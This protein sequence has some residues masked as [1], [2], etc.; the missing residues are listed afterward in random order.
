MA[1]RNALPMFYESGAGARASQRAALRS[2]S[3]RGKTLAPRTYGYAAAVRIPER[4]TSQIAT[5]ARTPELFVHEGARQALERRL[6]ASHTGP[7][8]LSI[9]DN[10]HSIISHRLARGVLKARI[11]H[12][13][14]D[15]PRGVVDALVRYVTRGERHASTLVG[16]FIEANGSRIDTRRR[17]L[18]LH[19]LGAHHDLLKIFEDVNARY[20]DGQCHALVTWGRKVVRPGGRNRKP[21]VSIKL[22][23]YSQTERVIRIHPVLDRQWVPRYFVA[24][25]LYH[26]MLHHMMPTS[27]GQAGRS[28]ATLH[29]PEFR[30]RERK[31]RHYER[32]IAW[33]RAHIARLLRA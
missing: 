32:A 12:M 6:Q 15:A 27:R 31:F 29:P 21:R 7:V 14:L 26:E 25:V 17:R 28:R 4:I 30:E 16:D 20:F 33:E 10:R 19:P 23:S 24:F 2:N 3:P 18:R 1:A 11:H 9:T 13:F 22:G 8:I 5:T